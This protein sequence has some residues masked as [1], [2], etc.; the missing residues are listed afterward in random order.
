MDSRRKFIILTPGFPSS[1]LDTTCLPMQ[2]FFVRTLQEQYPS[3]QVIVIS[4]QYP[5]HQQQYNWFGIP[6][7][8]FG[9]RN[10]GGVARLMLRKKLLKKLEEIHRRPGIAGILSFWYN[11]CAFVGHAFAKTHGLPHRCWI[12]GQDARKDNKYP[13]RTGLGGPE[14]VALSDF[15][16]QEF[17]RNHGARPATVIPP[18]VD[19]AKFENPG[20]PRPVPVIGVGS[21]IPLKQYDRWIKIIAGIK[22]E[23]ALTTAV[24]IGAGP[25]EKKILALIQQLDLMQVVRLTGEISHPAVMDLMQ[26]ARVFLHTSS[27]EGFSGVCLEALAAGCQVISFVQ[28][29]NEPISNWMVVADENEMIRQA[30]A[31]LLQPQ[32]PITALPVYSMQDCVHRMMELFSRDLPP[33]AM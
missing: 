19:A 23:Y 30:L 18:G 10:R 20:G 25:E 29:M 26:Q 32:R 9:G 16:Q 28:P 6:V 21:L 4:F 2:Q 8:P 1:E 33:A 7:I 24:L 22:K 17:L 5:Y 27:Y 15:L 3:F 13:A 14:L 12:L 11:E 31:V